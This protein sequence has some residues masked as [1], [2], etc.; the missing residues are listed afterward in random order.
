MN[1]L[2]IAMHLGGMACAAKCADA[3]IIEHIYKLLHGCA[4][5]VGIEHVEDNRWATGL[6]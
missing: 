6:I 2:V 5:I 3:L 4:G 1:A